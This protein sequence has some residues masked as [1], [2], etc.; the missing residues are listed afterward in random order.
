MRP[1]YV[2]TSE[3]VFTGEP[4]CDEARPLAVAVQGG[5]V[6][7]VA[8]REEAHS[9]ARGARVED[10][11]DAFVCPGFHDAHQHVFHAALFPSDLATEYVGT[12]EADCVRH[13]RE[14]AATRHDDGSW[15]V[16]HGWREGA[17]DSLAMPSRASLD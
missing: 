4:G 5:R 8:P 15:L 16:S 17:W 14:W 10:W 3:R 2:I 6:A 12:S 13:L 1:D 11:D 9:L 7:A